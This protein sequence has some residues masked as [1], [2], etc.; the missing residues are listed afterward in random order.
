MPTSLRKT[1]FIVLLVAFIMVE[2]L[3]A[4]PFLPVS[5]DFD[6]TF[7]PA[8]RY[9]LAG[10]NP[11]Q[12]EYEYLEA[13][14]G[15]PPNFFSPPWL[16]LILLPFGFFPLELAR[17][18]WMIFLTG[19]TAV[20]IRLMHPAKGFKGLWPFALVALPWSLVGILFGQVS[21][22]VLLGAVICIMELESEESGFPS[23]LKLL[24]GLLLVGLKPQLGGLIA[25]P[26]IMWMAWRRDKRLTPILLIGLP[27]IG[28]TLLVSQLVQDAENVYRIAPLWQST[29]ERELIVWS[30]PLWLAHLVRI[31][32][33][34]TMAAWAWRTRRLDTG[35]WSAW[36]AAVL[37]ITPYT[38]AYDG[39]LLLPL[40][41]Q[42]A[43]R[44]QWRQ[45]GVFLLITIL[46]IQLPTGELGSIVAPLAAWLLF[47]P[48]R[49][50]FPIAKQ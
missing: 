21:A 22:L 26:V 7:Y 43:S 42:I 47:V 10:E 20:G 36:L 8:I 18:L 50:I 1:I 16:L 14:P 39:V 13:N 44:R 2:A 15:A 5:L 9:A 4:A 31:L 3:V 37:I 48:W 49:N 34:G 35:W 11:Y 33:L 46:Y 27:V 32:V 41:G 25:L 24:A 6:Q 23:T 12:T 28:L 45:A 30:Q 19:V 38:R 29:L 40:F 17:A